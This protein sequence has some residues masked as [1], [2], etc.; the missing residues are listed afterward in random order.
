MLNNDFLKKL[1]NGTYFLELNVS[2]VKKEIINGK[3]IVLKENKI[4]I[5]NLADIIYKNNISPEFKKYII[6]SLLI[7]LNYLKSDKKFF[8]KKLKDNKTLNR[9]IFYNNCIFLSNHLIKKLELEIENFKK[10]DIKTV[11]DHFLSEKNYFGPFP[12]IDYIIIKYILNKL[13]NFKFDNFISNSL[14]SLYIYHENENSVKISLL[15]EY[16]HD[17][18][19]NIQ[20]I[21]NKNYK[22]NLIKKK[23]YI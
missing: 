22:Y 5:L 13:L 4:Y 14:N 15:E 3:N 6:E 19:N 12:K 20:I 2:Y 10:D 1:S 18:D 9:F 17:L 23:V 8:Y 21:L 7:R 11:S 16:H